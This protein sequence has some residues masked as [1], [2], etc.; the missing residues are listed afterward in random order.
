MM[1]IHAESHHLESKKANPKLKEREE[2]IINE[3]KNYV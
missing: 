1:N 2:T 3:L